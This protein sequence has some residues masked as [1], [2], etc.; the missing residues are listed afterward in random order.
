MINRRGSSPTRRLAGCAAAA[1]LW[2][3]NG[4]SAQAAPVPEPPPTADAHSTVVSGLDVAIQ[5]T[6]A[7]WIHK[8]SPSTMNAFLPESVTKKPGHRAGEVVLKCKLHP[9]GTVSNCAVIDETN[10]AV[11]FGEAALKASTL[12][13]IKPRAANGIATDENWVLIPVSFDFD[14]TVKRRN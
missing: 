9:D 14:V 8:P 7:D 2:A 4:A 13:R 10:P 6:S 3:T 5:I 1:A 11:P 12:F